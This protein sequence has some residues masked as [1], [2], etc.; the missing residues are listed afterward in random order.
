VNLSSL[1]RL[2]LRPRKKAAMAIRITPT[3]TPITIPAMAPPDSPDDEEDGA[4]AGDVDAGALVVLR[5]IDIGNAQPGPDV[6]AMEAGSTTS[7][8]R[9]DALFFDKSTRAT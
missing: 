3:T 6:C 9:A 2:D 7:G 4:T 1:C 8:R 5:D